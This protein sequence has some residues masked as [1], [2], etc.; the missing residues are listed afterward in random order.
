M[1]RDHYEEERGRQLREQKL[2]SELPRIM[3]P[4]SWQP[5]LAALRQAIP[6]FRERDKLVAKFWLDLEHSVHATDQQANT[7]SKPSST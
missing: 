4:E 7:P 2:T 3:P 5:I 6:D 1:D